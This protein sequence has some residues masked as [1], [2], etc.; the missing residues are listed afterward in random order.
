MIYK[1]KQTEK[2]TVLPNVI[3]DEL[4]DGLAIGILAYL[5]SKPNDWVTYKQQLYSYFTE[6]RQR[7]DKSFKLLEDKGFIVGVQK[8]N[9]SGQ[10][11]G[12]EW[13]V[14]NEPVVNASEN[15][16]TEN[17]LLENQQSENEQLLN[18]EYTKERVNKDI[19]LPKNKFSEDVYKVFEHTVLL[20]KEEYRPSTE[21]QK[22]NWLDCI[23]KLNRIDGMEYREIY[24]MVKW[25]LEHDFWNKNFYTILKLRKKN[26]EGISYLKVFKSQMEFETKQVK[27]GS[28]STVEMI[29]KMAK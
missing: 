27:T 25:G 16:L 5:L 26:S 20:F 11:N 28:I 14:Y 3:F 23:E 18:K 21:S 4:N 1:S 29:K 15:R 19:I 22:N 17:R 6:G 12:F 24:K 7:I 10:F 8:V 2:F 9:N 13:I